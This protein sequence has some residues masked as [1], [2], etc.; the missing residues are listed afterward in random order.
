[1]ENKDNI[2]KKLE[3]YLKDKTCSGCYNK[4]SFLEPKCGKH[5]IFKR[6]IIEEYNKKRKI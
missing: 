5:K 3:D 4:C 1:M 6:Y 2:D